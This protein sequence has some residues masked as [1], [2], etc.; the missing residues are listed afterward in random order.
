MPYTFETAIREILIPSHQLQ[1]Y[2]AKHLTRAQFRLEKGVW[3]RRCYLKPRVLEVVL[4]VPE[5]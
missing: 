5:K 4:D 2:E 3:V 1:H